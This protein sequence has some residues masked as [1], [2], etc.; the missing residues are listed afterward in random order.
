MG[1]IPKYKLN[2]KMVSLVADISRIIGSVSALSN[3]DKNPKLRRANRIRTIHDSLAIEQN[4]LTLEQV[5]SVLNGKMVIAPPKDIQEVK[6]AYEIY[7]LIDTLDPYSVDDLLKAH[8]VMTRG[9]VEES[10][11]F[12]TKPVGVVDSKS[13]EVIHVGTLPAYVPQAV[14]DLLQWLKSDDTNDII[15]SCIF[16]FAFESIHPFLD[17]NGRTGRLWQTLILSKVDSIFAYLP[18]ESM[19]YKKQDEY[20]RAINDSDYAGEST[21][22]IIFMLETIK[23]SLVEATTQ[24]DIQSDKINVTLDEQEIIDLIVDD[25]NITQIELAKALNV[26]D[27]TIK[28][29][30]KAMQEK[31]IIFREN[32]KRNGKWVVNTKYINLLK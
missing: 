3:F 19:I 15:K 5:T 28:R 27:R 10:G 2:N 17:G 8:G 7:E 29:R 9:L 16:H 13:G 6:N 11:V 18:V 31:E 25:P 12:R 21:E 14:E 1:Y 24:S 26:T 32:G 30:M 20:Y 23:D 22:F 4:T